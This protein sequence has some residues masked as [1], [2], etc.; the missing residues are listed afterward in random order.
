M[1]V[2]LG[3]LILLKQ[4]VFRHFF[5]FF[6]FKVLKMDTKN[7]PAQAG[8]KPSDSFY[9]YCTAVRN[10][11]LRYFASTRIK[12]LPRMQTEI[13]S[14]IATVMALNGIVTLIPWK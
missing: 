11:T 1:F 5:F 8:G 12:I 3:I 13:T 10:T 9:N 7:P 4:T 6:G 14:P 2:A